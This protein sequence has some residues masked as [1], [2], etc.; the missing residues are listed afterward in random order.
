[1]L[2]LKQQRE[3]I[4]RRIQENVLISNREPAPEAEKMNKKQELAPTWIDTTP[5]MSCK[6]GIPNCSMRVRRQ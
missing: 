6:G 2:N 3:S 5:G 4:A 1:V